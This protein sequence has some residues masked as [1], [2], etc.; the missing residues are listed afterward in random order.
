MPEPFHLFA[1]NMNSAVPR[2]KRGIKEAVCWA[3]K[4]K[5]STLTLN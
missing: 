3:I 1:I 4:Q 5:H 2:S